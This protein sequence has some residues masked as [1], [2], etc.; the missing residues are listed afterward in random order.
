MY[1]E[2]QETKPNS[3]S[4]LSLSGSAKGSIEDLRKY[5]ERNASAGS[6]DS[7][8]NLGIPSYR[9]DSM[10]V[11]QRPQED[12]DKRHKKTEGR[13]H[14]GLDEQERKRQQE[15]DERRRKLEE[16]DRKMQQERERK[17]QEEEEQQRRKRREEEAKKADDQKHQEEAR[18]TERLS[19]LFGL[20]RKKEEISPAVNNPK[21]L[22]TAG[23]A[24]KFEEIPLGID[25]AN[26][27]TEDKQ[28]EP[29]K[30]VWTAF[31]PTP[32]SSGF[33]ARTAKVS[34]VKPR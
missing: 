27:F 6:V 21:Q 1:D 31:T 24:N 10:E 33:P 30:E 28:A 11:Q 34:A 2:E 22:E 12:E 8:K 25:N 16:D 14:D 3:G 32:S 23:P 5:H 18:V 4:T 13:L 26:S 17:R 15:Q 29:Q 20:G 7:F 9:P 19:S